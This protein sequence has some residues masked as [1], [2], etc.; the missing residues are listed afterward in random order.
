MIKILFVE[1]LK[2][3]SS[4][5]TTEHN[6]FEK[7]IFVEKSSEISDSEMKINL[8]IKF[9]KSISTFSHSIFRMF[10]MIIK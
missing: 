2:I 4:S 6:C 1:K 10:F 7:C 8:I 9:S 5:V 3:E